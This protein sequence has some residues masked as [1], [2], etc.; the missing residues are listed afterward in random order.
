M[1]LFN[2]EDVCLTPKMGVCD[3]RSQCDTSIEFLGT[4]FKLPV[5]PSNMKAVIDF[6]HANHLSQEGYFY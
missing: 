4:K 1:R 5:M 3:S 6:E 2:Y